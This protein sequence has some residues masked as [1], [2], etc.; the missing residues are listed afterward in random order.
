MEKMENDKTV[1]HLSHNP[2]YDDDGLI[3]LFLKARPTS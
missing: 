2:G 1:S 3:S